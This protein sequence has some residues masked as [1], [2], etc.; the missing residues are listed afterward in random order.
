MKRVYLDYNA[1]SP[2][3]P[4]VAKGLQKALAI[5]GNPSSLHAE[6]RAAKEAVEDAR[7]KIA[8]TIDAEP[9]Q[10]IFTGSGTEA[11]NH[12]VSQAAGL[13][14]TSEIEHPS[15]LEACDATYLAVSRQG[16]IDTGAIPANAALVS[17]M[18]ANN[19]TGVI[20][21]IPRLSIPVHTDAVQAL[22]K[23]SFSFK[24]LGVDFMT[25]SAHKIG[26]L[27]GVGAL[28]V[29]DP[30][31]FKAM[32]F[33]GP[34]EQRLRAGTENVPG[35]IAFGIAVEHIQ[36]V[37]KQ[38]KLQLLHGIETSIS[39][40]VINGH[41]DQTLSNTLN[42]SFPGLK[43]ESLVIAL[44]LAGVAASTGS[45][46]S[47]GSTEPSHVLL[48]MYKDKAI[49]ESSVRFSLGPDTT[50]ADIV[51]VLDVLPGLVKKLRDH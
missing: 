21:S 23:L 16:I 24:A 5:F 32:L 49:A 42:V 14:V 33:G 27:K 48:A 12:V 46:C 20:Q 2:V 39:N 3:H 37:D 10:I 51:Y 43:G 38:L 8:R 50:H 6:G 1:T 22:G 17:V 47:T 18:L 36:A 15:I 31:K 29:K 7:E 45:A 19:E 35:I 25:L 13:V 9:D 26:G 41:P 4:E 11:N 44:D 30:K 28:V 34:Q 40:A